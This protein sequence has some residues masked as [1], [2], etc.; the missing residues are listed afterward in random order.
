MECI[1]TVNYDA[2]LDCRVTLHVLVALVPRIH[3]GV[4]S[5][6]VPRAWSGA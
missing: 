4:R 1:L 5:C 6:S 2:P 3:S